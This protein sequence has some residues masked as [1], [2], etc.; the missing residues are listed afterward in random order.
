MIFLGLKII[1]LVIDK[2]LETLLNQNMKNAAPVVTSREQEIL[3]RLLNLEAT[4][5]NLKNTILNVLQEHEVICAKTGVYKATSLQNEIV[6]TL[7]RK[8]KEEVYPK[9][10]AVVDQTTNEIEKLKKSNK[11]PFDVKVLDY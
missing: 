3:R 10:Q 2:H 1:E 11:S 7:D 9:L 6:F 5:N 4:V 8:L